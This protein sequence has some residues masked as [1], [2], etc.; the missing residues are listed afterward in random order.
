MAVDH[1]GGRTTADPVR[2]ATMRDVAA[3]SGVS[4]KTVSRVVN[5]VSTVSE[6]LRDRVMRAVAQLDFRPNL[7]ASSLRRTDGATRQIALLLENVANRSCGLLGSDPVQPRAPN[8][9]GRLGPGFRIRVATRIPCVVHPGRAGSLTTR[10]CGR[11][12]RRRGGPRPSHWWQG[13][14]AR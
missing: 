9:L 10:P 8:G 11:G 6:E 5:D 14:P 3:L 12:Q 2:R 7:A 13:G 1:N 4:L